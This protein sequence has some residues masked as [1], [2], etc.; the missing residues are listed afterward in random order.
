MNEYHFSTEAAKRYGVDE[1]IFL[2]SLAFWVEKNEANVNNFRDGRYWTYNTQK[3]LAYLYPFWTPRQIA[4][5]SASCEEKGA[6][7]TG[8]YGEDKSD[9]TKWY[10]LTDEAAEL[11]FDTKTVK[12]NLPNGEL[13]E[14]QGVGEIRD[15][16]VD[17]ISPNGDTEPCHPFHQTVDCIKGN[18]CLPVE[19]IPP[20]SPKGDKP[21]RGGLSA[22][23]KTMIEEYARGYPDLYG[24]LVEYLEDQVK[25]RVTK[26]PAAV[27]RLLLKLDK[28][29]GGSEVLK[30]Q[31]LDTAIERSWRSVF[32]LRSDDA[33]DKPGGAP[34]DEEGKWI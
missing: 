6:I 14:P 11:Y 15:D 32:P 24:L 34:A 12:C 13:I 33:W 25:A 8:Y 2:H 5:I 20:I 23:V 29:S 26:S 7:L 1:A 10:T 16:G 17:T 4:R 21:T 22:E 19:D 27:K 30:R 28:L 3:A 31:L 9:R 18:S